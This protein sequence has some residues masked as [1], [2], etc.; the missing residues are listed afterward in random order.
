MTTSADTQQ[1]PLVSFI[2]TYYNLPTDLLCQCIDSILRLSLRPDE[3]E[4]IIVDDGSDQSPMNNLLRYGDEITYVRKKNGGL[5]TARN[6]GIEVARGTYLQFVDAD[7]QLIRASYEHCLDIIRS[8]QDADMVLFDFDEQNNTTDDVPAAEPTPVSGTDYM[9]HHNIHGMACGYLCRRMTVADLRF[10]PGIYHE[11][12]EFTPLL[13]L[14]AERIYPTT[15][16]AYYYNKRPDSI[17]TKQDE[18]HTTKRM[19]DFLGVIRRLYQTAD[20]LPHN[21]QLALE[22]RVAQLTMDYIHNAILLTPSLTAVKE[23]L[24]ELRTYNLFPLPDKSYTKK[25]KWF[26]QLTNHDLGLMLLVKLL[27]RLKKER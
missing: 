13:L 19:D 16:K 21:E 22:R 18:T 20:R 4:I 11:D 17:I 14:R 26:R 10:T 7:D 23:K 1:Q 27:P 9:R 3:R 12:E 15:V 2:L 5:S 25:Y 24:R 6:Q 8:H